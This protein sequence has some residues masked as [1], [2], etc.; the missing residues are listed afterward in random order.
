MSR[1]E[2]FERM[3]FNFR[4]SIKAMENEVTS[5]DMSKHPYFEDTLAFAKSDLAECE[6][7]IKELKH[8]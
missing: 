8:E 1:L 2:I 7:Q 5:I 4:N 6:K 3:A